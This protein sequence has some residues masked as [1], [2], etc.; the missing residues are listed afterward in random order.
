MEDSAVAWV[1]DTL[2]SCLQQSW[3]SISQDFPQTGTGK[4]ARASEFSPEWSM[5]RR[6]TQSPAKFCTDFDN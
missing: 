6:R 2:T 1:L 4:A 3:T 5:K